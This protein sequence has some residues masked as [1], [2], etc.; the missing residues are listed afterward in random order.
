MILFRTPKPADDRLDELD[1]RLLIDLDHMGRFWP[2][3]KFVDANVN[4]LVPS[5]VTGEWPQDVQAP[6]NE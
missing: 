5:E 6:D 4:V 2:L 3:S 1:C